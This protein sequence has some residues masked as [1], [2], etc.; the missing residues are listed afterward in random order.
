MKDLEIHQFTC[1]EDNFGVLVHHG[2][3]GE[4]VSID[5]PDAGAIA[6][7]LA[8]KGWRL[9]HILVT[10]HH[11]DH[12]QGIAALKSDS[13][14]TVIGP[15]NPA[16]PHLDKAVRENEIIELAGDRVRVIATPGHTLDMLN[17]HFTKAGV[18]FTGDTLFSMG[19]GRVFEGTPA[20]MWNSLTKL[21]ALPRET[22]IYC[23]HEYTLSNARF[24]LK[25][26][27]QNEALKARAEEVE[28]LRAHGKPTLPTTLALELETNPF[29][30]AGDPA[31]RRNLG[32]EK[33]TDAE[34][35]A[36][37]RERK[38]RG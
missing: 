16:I 4:T 21:M 15:D 18:V 8:L 22:Q 36:E 34:V 14:C 12:V 1:L 10:H 33:A 25:I 6:S 26:D 19:C 38:N 32:M 29:L 24:S 30:R 9:T 37:I 28:N 35:F 2:Q 13:G 23:G 5:A 20:Q 17:Y 27:P 31:I 11:A 7:A 3:S